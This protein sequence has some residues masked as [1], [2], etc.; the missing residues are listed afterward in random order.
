VDLDLDADQIALQD[1]A[2]KLCEAQFTSEV[3]R[4]FGA[5]GGFDRGRWSQLCALGT[6]ALAL[7]EARGGVGLTI[8]DTVLVFEELGRGLVPGPLVASQLVAGVLPGV[9]DGERVV[10]IVEDGAGVLV[11]EHLDVADDVVIVRADGVWRVGA[12]EVVAQPSAR[13]VDPTSRV[14]VVE[15]LPVGERIIG[16]DE[17]APWRTTGSLL[18][19]AL[20][21]GVG[22]A[23]TEVATAYALER[24]QFGRAI[25]S[26]QAVKHML[27]DSFAR[28]EVARA[29]VYA[30]AVRAADSAP[31]DGFST[32][33]PSSDALPSGAARAAASARVLAERSAVA[34][35]KTAIQVHGGMGF[36]WEMDPHLYLKRA[37]ALESMCGGADDA[38]LS[39]AHDL[40]ASI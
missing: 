8:V 2:R 5:P 15:A 24:R 18:V 6:F 3:V 35:A 11:A 32:S 40:A 4:G 36:T 16:P 37:W 25:G 39:I 27:A 22:S 1:A 23:A 30:A 17:R 31:N 7:P 34:N 10:T 28:T 20:Q 12:S 29:A 33:A 9:V 19:A 14:S 26:F 38:A 13:A 21:L